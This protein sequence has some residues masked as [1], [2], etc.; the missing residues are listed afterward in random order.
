VSGF[1]ETENDNLER[2]EK[3]KKR[4]FDFSWVRF[5]LFFAFAFPAYMKLQSLQIL[6]HIW[7]R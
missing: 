1:E 5:D 7:I 2:N 4:A 6:M 3:K